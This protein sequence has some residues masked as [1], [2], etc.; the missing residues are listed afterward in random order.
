MHA[1]FWGYKMNHCQ[2]GPSY[3]NV[4]SCRKSRVKTQ[5][6][7]LPWTALSPLSCVACLPKS[8]SGDRASS[9]LALVWC[10]NN[11]QFSCSYSSKT[12]PGGS[13]FGTEASLSCKDKCNFYIFQCVKVHHFPP[14][15]ILIKIYL[16]PKTAPSFSFLK[17]KSEAMPENSR[18]IFWLKV[19]QERN[20][21]CGLQSLLC[22]SFCGS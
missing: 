10:Q 4:E 13:K 14:S 7:Q 9:S 19:L 17:T 15:W 11:C 2:D 5:N 18:E 3:Q 21:A 22:S 16:A 20:G 1:R 6:P 12:A 8:L